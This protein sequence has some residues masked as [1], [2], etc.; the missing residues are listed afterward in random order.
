MIADLVRTDKFKHVFSALLGLA[1]VIVVFKPACKGDDCAIWKAP[2]PTEVRDAVFKLGEKCYS[3]NEKN[4]ECQLN[5]K[6]IEAFRGEF[7]CRKR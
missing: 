6:Y 7:S 5:D 2:P 3:F 4:N 1:I